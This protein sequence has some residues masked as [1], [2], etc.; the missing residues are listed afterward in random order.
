M[1]ISKKNP[2]LKNYLETLLSSG[3]L[4]ELADQPEETLRMGGGMDEGPAGADDE[5]AKAHA[6]VE[7]LARGQDLDREEAFLIEAIIVPDKRPAIVVTNDAYNVQH[8]DWVHFNTNETTR[9]HI[10]KTLPAAG[11][12]ELPD[13]PYLPYGGTGFLVADDLIMTNR[14][15]A[16]L[17]ATGLGERGLAF[18]P[19]QTAGIDY[20]QEAGSTESA[21]AKITGIRM[22]HPHWDMALLQLEE[23]PD[24][25]EPLLLSMQEPEDL[26]GREITL[27]GYPAFDPRND[28]AVQ[29]RVFKGIYDVK[30]L[31]PGFLKSRREILSYGDRVNSVTHDASSLGGASGSLVLDVIT[32]DIVALH[33]AGRYKDANF[34]VPTYELSRD[35]K[36]VG[37]G[38][39][40][41]EDALSNIEDP[42]PWLSDWRQADGTAESAA[43]ALSQDNSG[44]AIQAPVQ[45]G[46]PGGSSRWTIPITIDIQV[47]AASMVSAQASAAIPA[48]QPLA[49]PA[50]ERMVEPKHDDDYTNRPGYDPSFIGLDVPVPKVTDLDRVSKLDDGSNFLK[51]YHFSIIMD[52]FRRMP[53][54]TAANVDTRK[55][56]LKPEPG[57]KYN[58]KALNGFT[59]DNDREKWFADPRIPG[60]HQLPDRFFNKDRKA[61]DKG[62]VVRRNAVVWGRTYEEVQLANGDT[63]HSTNCTPQVK[64][65]NRSREG[66]EWG[67]LENHIFKQAKTEKLC[68]LA[69]PVL[70]AEDPIFTGVDDDGVT[71]V[72]IPQSYWKV[73]VA[74]AEGELQAFAFQLEQ[75][76]SDVA[77]EFQLTQKWKARQISL[78]DLEKVLAVVKFDKVLHAA[79]QAGTGAGEAVCADAGIG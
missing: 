54:V 56:S 47:G 70:K 48:G 18:R 20:K 51:Y 49:A 43:V 22:I 66:G 39:E 52:K 13:H 25:V 14:H 64:G 1:P 68:V 74:N 24:G 15:V 45:T 23:A 50:I 53:L 63:F 33:F 30:R 32:G 4:A 79:D 41:G 75:D 6:A 65:F 29:N 62:H 67:Q 58:R 73:A 7:K 31:L 9:R 57:R 16:E 35:D 71:K 59:S 11:R 8:K 77:F 12:I 19:G 42:N 40:F 26:E 5:R 78:K 55:S 60:D 37:A 46:D 10:L 3:D 76:L 69:G 21:F 72:R 38:L 27:I 36:V 2:D 61:F 44:S 17:F 34:A 28:A